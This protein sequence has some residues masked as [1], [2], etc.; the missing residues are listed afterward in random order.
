MIG[1]TRRADR[2]MIEHTSEI[3]GGPINM[4]DVS[5]NLKKVNFN[6]LLMIHDM[7]DT[8]LPF[9]NSFEI[10]SDHQNVQLISMKK[11]GHYRMLWNDEVIGR[12]VAFVQGK[13]VL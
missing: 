8:V 5:A 9:S 11:V 4:M 1:L 2:F 7:D 3:L 13:E 12:T 10:N 6:K